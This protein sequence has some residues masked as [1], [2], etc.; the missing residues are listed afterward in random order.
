MKYAFV[1][2]IL[3]FFIPK[4]VSSQ[5]FV[6]DYGIDTTPVS[7]VLYLQVENGSEQVG[8]VFMRSHNGIDFNEWRWF[9]PSLD[10]RV[11][12]ILLE[13]SSPY[14]RSYYKIV[15]VT[16]IGETESEVLSIT[17]NVTESTAY[18]EEKRI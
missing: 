6:T 14:E 11:K 17:A 1:L 2:F 4:D 8:Y 13:D 3:S 10:N 7:V 16:A 18:Y 15:E 9:V 5:K 12:A